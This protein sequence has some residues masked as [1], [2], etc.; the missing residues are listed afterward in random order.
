MVSNADTK[1]HILRGL[2]LKSAALLL[3]LLLLLLFCL[4]PSTFSMFYSSAYVYFAWTCIAVVIV[5][6]LRHW[7][8]FVQFELFKHLTD[9]VIFLAQ[10]NVRLM[11]FKEKKNLVVFFCFRFDIL[12][13]CYQFVFMYASHARL[14]T[15]R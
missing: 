11:R 8:N 1:G 13:S 10:N 9:W 14:H 7:S 6:D 2:R 15:N 3:L 12:F 5:F 4:Y